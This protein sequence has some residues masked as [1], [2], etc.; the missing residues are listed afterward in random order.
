MEEVTVSYDAL[1]EY[2]GE[3][4]VNSETA[5]ILRAINE[6]KSI[7][8]ASKALGIPYTR[9][10][11]TISKIERLAGRKIVKAKKGGKGGGKAELT[12]F[13]KQLL[14]AYDKAI[15]KIE[16]FGLIGKQKI[17]EKPE[18]VIAHSHD[19]LFSAVI[20]K[21]SEY[22]N[23][24][25]LC[26]GSGMALAMFTLGEAD[27][28]C[29]H[30]YDPGT[31][32]Y[33]TGFLE[34]FWLKDKVEKVG[35]IKREVVIAYRKDLKFGSIEDLIFEILNGKLRVANRNRGSGTR[36]IFD[37]VLSDYSNKL[38][39]DNKNVCGY[40]T[41]FFTHEEVANQ[42]SKSNFDVGVLIR[43]FAEKYDLKF[44]HLA[45]EFYECFAL[46][47]RKSRAVEHLKEI[48]NSEWFRSLIKITPGYDI[49]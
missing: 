3:K 36:Q 26:V 28:A 37:K 12:E 16:K 30:L 27:V 25:S 35:T 6:N 32:I 42:I 23:V 4:I 41:E 11:N 49:A 9:L 31:G 2:R 45:W 14:E 46:K 40:E 17:V 18:I 21:L 24:K 5:S 29:L 33:N 8:S 22:F 48:M 44:F 43:Y 1:I 38:K 20:E 13:G 7:I 19:P 47:N 34:K 15:A 10:W 39:I